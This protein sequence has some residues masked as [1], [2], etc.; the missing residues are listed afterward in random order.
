MIGTGSIRVDQAQWSQ[1]VQAET[2]AQ[3]G[4]LHTNRLI[5]SN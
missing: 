5:M 4:H 2:D 1:P 3:P